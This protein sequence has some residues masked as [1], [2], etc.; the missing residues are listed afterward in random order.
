MSIK[1]RFFSYFSKFMSPQTLGQILRYLV[2]G[3]TAFG[4]EYGLYVL[5]LKI[6]HMH[7]IVASVLVYAL[8]FWFV[9]LTNRYWSFKSEGSIKR[10]LF[11]Y[12]LLFAFNLVVANVFLMAF[13]TDTLGVSEYLSPMLK[14]ACMVCWNFL[15]YKYLIYK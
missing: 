2:T 13:L 4:I 8:V 14:M 9:F 11:Q 12:C 3:F 10:Q 5:L 1:D 15:I 7:Y 6:W